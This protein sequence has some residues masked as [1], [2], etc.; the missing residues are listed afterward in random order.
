MGDEF[1]T[2]FGIGYKYRDSRQDVSDQFLRRNI[3][4]MGHD[5]DE[6]P[7][8]TGLFKEIL[9]RDIIFLKTA[10]MQER[11][12][13]IRA[14]GIANNPEPQSQGRIGYGINVNWIKDFE[15]NIQEI[16]NPSDGGWHPRC[17]S[18]YKEYNPR[19]TQFIDNLLNG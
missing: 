7:Y 13:K 2:T 17:G 3:A 18:I 4:C 14:I 10:P 16:E 1:M 12:L 6:Y 8:Y 9:N 19:I 11:I 5:P 15:N